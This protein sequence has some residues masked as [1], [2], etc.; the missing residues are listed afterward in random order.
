MMHASRAAYAPKAPM[1]AAQTAEYAREGF[2]SPL[3]RYALLA[4]VAGAAVYRFGGAASGDET[5]VLTRWIDA[6]ST[7]PAD[8]RE[9]NQR[10]LDWSLRKADAQLLIQDATKPDAYRM[11]FLP[12]FQQFPQR[13][14]PTGGM[15]D[16]SDIKVNPER[17]V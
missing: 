12:A 4:G 17:V 1:S 8:T 15:V 6:A 10:H 2:T 11:K 14:M 3:W 5:P 16:I 7:P 9:N 13:G